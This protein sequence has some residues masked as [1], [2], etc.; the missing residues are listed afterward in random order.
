VSPLLSPDIPL[1]ERELDK[2]LASNAGGRVL[3]MRSPTQ[4]GWPDVIERGGRRFRL[5]WCPSQLDVRERLDEI[6]A[7]GSEG[8][9]V[10]TPLDD[11]DLGSD[12]T[13]RLPR[14]RLAQ[15]DRWAVLRSV[16]RVRDVDS[17]LRSQRWL[18]DL[19]IDRAPVG[20]YPAPASG[21][22]ELET[23]WRA[24]QENVL[25]LPAGRTDA[26]ALL[27]WTL[28]FA[29]LDRFASLPD[30]ARRAVAERL[31]GAGGCGAG[32]V[33]SAAA[34]GRGAD[35]LPVALVCGVIFGEPEPRPELREAAVRLEPLV[36][37]TRISPEAGQALATAARRVLTRLA[38]TDVAASGSAQTRAGVLL[39]EVRA[40]AAAALSPALNLGI[41]AR[42]KNAAAA[43]AAVAISANGDD[44]AR[45]W[46]LTQ[47][48][49]AHDR[50][51]DRRV[52][53]DRLVMAA[54]LAVW[55]AGR[56]AAPPGNMA[57][58]T[59]TYAQDSGFVD[60]ARH[61]L[62]SGDPLPEVATAYARLREVV[63]AR[64][65]T[66]N[67]AFAAVLRTWN[68]AGARGAEPVPVERLLD[69]IVAPLA[70]DV[71]ILFLVFD[72]L[73][74]AVWRHLAE[75]LPRLGWTEFRPRGRTATP[76]A[77]AVL[78]TVTEVSRTSLLCGTLS[79]GD[80]ST[81]RAG[82]ATHAG[83]VAASGAG[84]PPRLFHK[85][86][87]R[88]LASLF[89]PT[90]LP[91]FWSADQFG[92]GTGDL[93]ERRSERCWNGRYGVCFLT[94]STTTC[95]GLNGERALSRPKH[96]RL[97]RDRKASP[98]LVPL[99]SHRY[100]PSE[101]NE[102]GNPIFSIYQSDVIYYGADLADYFEREFGNT[103]TPVVG[104]ARPIRFW[105]ELVPRNA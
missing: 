29:G 16:F 15:S 105:S 1:I 26:A 31:A 33:L 67:Q 77:A 104:P 12:V 99:V 83:L 61:A 80:Q 89:P 44:A 11:A 59:A 53:V 3:G 96:E 9:V 85:A 103:R 25:G 86:L 32:L 74:F 72:G 84:R 91:S 48:V 49:A 102:A 17:R 78:P 50:K 71:P 97:G 90:S 101:P 79:R 88:S 55:L 5:A 10:L 27:E 40:E 73:S 6:E 18:A 57:E 4:R 22:L 66:G 2:L 70:R 35:A 46:E 81:E 76:A 13:A 94:S 45:A 39:A 47:H 24:L 41:E 28:D 8:M 64:R 58:A 87:R 37:G 38:G 98:K 95:G 100:L 51:D 60:R 69:L 42:M 52:Y 19:L 21:M 68:E 20:G 54:R 92:A 82:F 43:L 62:Q 93:T 23:A 56:R 34:A 36:G 65:E 7:D 63:A 30:D 75:S 14:G